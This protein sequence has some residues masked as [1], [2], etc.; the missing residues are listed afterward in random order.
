[1]Q[2]DAHVGFNGSCEAAFKF[3]EKALGGKIIYLKTYGET[4]MG[5]GMPAG[6]D[7]KI[8]HASL[9]LGD[10]LLMGS[11]APPERFKPPQG[12]TLS[13]DAKDPEEAERLFQALSEKAQVQMPMQETFWARRFGMLTDQFGI[14][15]MV[16][17]GKPA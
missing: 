9:K 1:M 12:F 14:P 13:L 7:K 2:L 17:C 15:W 10:R 3:Y 8:I 6:W 11:D 4:P 16:N 5:A